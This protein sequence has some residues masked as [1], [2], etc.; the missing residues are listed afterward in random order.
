MALTVAVFAEEQAAAWVD[1]GYL[2]HFV[3]RVQEIWSR[4]KERRAC[5]RP[6][7]FCLPTT[8]GGQP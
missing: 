8:P 1:L 6:V 7:R 4:R 5:P 3:G 2:G